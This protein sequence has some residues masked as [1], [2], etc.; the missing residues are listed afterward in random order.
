VND[1]DPVLFLIDSGGFDDM[2]SPKFARAS[3]GVSG[4]SDTTV[5]G[6]SGAVNR[7]Y[8][9]DAVK[10]QFSHFRHDREGLV[11]FDLSQISDGAGTEIAGIL[12]FAM[13]HLLDVKIDYR[14]GLV[15]FQFDP[16]RFH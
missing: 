9:A 5:K 3:T 11:A 14:D 15:D 1:S 8:R 2:V 13:L 12:G 4:D 16:D 10:L 6:I 7:V